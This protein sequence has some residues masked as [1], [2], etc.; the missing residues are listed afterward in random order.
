MSTATQA[1]VRRPN[2]ADVSAWL[3]MRMQPS[4]LAV[5]GIRP[6]SACLDGPAYRN[7]RTAVDADTT[8]EFGAVKHGDD[9]TDGKFAT[10]LGLTTWT[11]PP[12]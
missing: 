8:P 5:A 12:V 2:P 7:V 11:P 6:T 10:R 1:S 9:A 3:T 4:M